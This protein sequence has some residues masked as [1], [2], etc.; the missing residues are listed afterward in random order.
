LARIHRLAPP[1]VVTVSLLP[2]C[3]PRA[4]VTSG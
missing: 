2:E 1:F 3:K 4:T